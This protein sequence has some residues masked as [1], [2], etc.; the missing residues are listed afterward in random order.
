MSYNITGQYL[1]N[2]LQN[3]KLVCC[4]LVCAKNNFY[5]YEESGDW[6]RLGQRNHRVHDQG[7]DFGVKWRQLQGH[8]S[9]NN[10]LATHTTFLPYTCLHPFLF[11]CLPLFSILKV[12]N[13]PQFALAHHSLKSALNSLYFYILAACTSVHHENSYCNNILISSPQF[14][15]K[16]SLSLFTYICACHLHPE[17]HQNVPQKTQ[18]WIFV[19]PTWFALGHSEIPH[20]MECLKNQ[21][22]MRAPM[23]SGCVC[24]R[25]RER[26]KERERER[27]REREGDVQGEGGRRERG[28]KV[29]N[30]VCH[31]DRTSTAT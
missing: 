1:L 26:K 15:S 4:K 29:P 6:P 12:T 27:E 24:E 31:R 25:E 19:Q 9:H 20:G 21:I 5:K 10:E 11:D 23:A 30:F 17:F 7:E 18:K 16:L 13:S 14:A 2:A 3:H 28:R 8:P 22:Q